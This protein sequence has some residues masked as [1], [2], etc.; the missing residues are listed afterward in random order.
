[1]KTPIPY[2]KKHLLM[3][4][5]AGHTSKDGFMIRKGIPVS[6]LDI[7]DAITTDLQLNKNAKPVRV[8]EVNGLTNL[9]P[10]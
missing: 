6:R 7:A 2:A 9:K 1:M 5:N 3:T 8:I 4:K 10:D